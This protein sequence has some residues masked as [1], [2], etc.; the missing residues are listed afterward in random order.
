MI[1]LEGGNWPRVSIW[2]EPPGLPLFLRLGLSFGFSF[3]R[4][5]SDLRVEH[6]LCDPTIDVLRIDFGTIPEA[7]APE[8]LLR[9][10][11][12]GLMTMGTSLPKTADMARS[13]PADW[14][15]RLRVLG[16]LCDRPL[17]LGW[18]QP[19]AC[20]I[21]LRRGSGFVAL[22]IPLLG[23]SG[24]V[25]KIRDLISKREVLLLF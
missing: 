2:D 24:R 3:G 10:W 4:F 11:M 23:W 9:E 25:W 16:S 19:F 18:C 1:M 12:Q 20:G 13:I 5:L 6:G 14:G 17:D 8:D 21:S 22:A 15:L 7:S